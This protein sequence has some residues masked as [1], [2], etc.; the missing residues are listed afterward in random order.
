[1]T[2]GSWKGHWGN[3]NRSNVALCCPDWNEICHKEEESLITEWA[4]DRAD[5]SWVEEEWE[6][7]ARGRGM[8]LVSLGGSSDRCG[9]D[10]L[11]ASR[12][13]ELIGGGPED[14]AGCGSHLV[15]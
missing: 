7:R 14:C 12:V 9:L 10:K 5:V 2:A 15:K 6:V 11:V 3:M 4:A 1:M 8:C 13:W